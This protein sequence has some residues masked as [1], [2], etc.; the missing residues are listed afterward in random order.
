MP[1]RARAR[2]QALSEGK[3]R[4]TPGQHGPHWAWEFHRPLNTYRIYTP[5]GLTA[6]EV[7]ETSAFAARSWKWREPP[8][9]VAV[10][11]RS[12]E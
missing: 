8:V 10:Q 3:C 12:A 5:V 9:A 1:P 2:A 4:A 6:G 11:E 7:A